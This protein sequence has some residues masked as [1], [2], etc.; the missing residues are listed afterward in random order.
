MTTRFTY[1]NGRKA[2]LAPEDDADTFVTV[3]LPDQVASDPAT[4][5]ASGR[6]FIGLL[7]DG[8]PVT[9]EITGLMF[10]PT[11]SGDLDIFHIDVDRPMTPGA[12]PCRLH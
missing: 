11:T 7:D 5:F 9:L 10:L 2:D 1:A 6:P 4:W 3:T 12:N 8:K